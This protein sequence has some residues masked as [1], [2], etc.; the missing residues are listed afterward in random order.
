MC[1]HCRQILKESNSDAL[2]FSSTYLSHQ[3]QDQNA[4]SQPFASAAMHS[5]LS[6]LHFSSTSPALPLLWASCKH[7]RPML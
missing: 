5:T 3:S 7:Q 1:L 2:T 4:G 6:F